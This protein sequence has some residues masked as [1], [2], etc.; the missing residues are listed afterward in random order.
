MGFDNRGYYLSV[1][2]HWDGALGHCSAMVLAISGGTISD[3]GTRGFLLNPLLPS[4][5]LFPV[6]FNSLLHWFHIVIWLLGFWCYQYA[7]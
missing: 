6:L 3:I 2:S 7:Y 4:K 5:V 1:L